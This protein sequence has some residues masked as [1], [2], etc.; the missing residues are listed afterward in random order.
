M[1]DIRTSMPA[2]GE[3]RSREHSGSTTTIQGVPVVGGSAVAV[4]RDRL[5]ASPISLWFRP[6]RSSELNQVR[7]VGETEGPPEEGL[8]RG[9]VTLA[10]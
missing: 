7:R 8:Q 1:F 9:G 2:F 5:E 4:L 3:H 10:S 6:G